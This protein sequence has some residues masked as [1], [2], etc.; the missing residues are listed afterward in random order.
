MLKIWLDNRGV[1][2]LLQPL[3]I[4]FYGPL[5]KAYDRECNLFLKSHPLRKI[6]NY[7]IAELFNKAYGRVAAIEKAVKGFATA[8]IYPL[9]PNIFDGDYPD[10]AD[11]LENEQQPCTCNDPLDTHTAVSL[12]DHSRQKP[13]HS[14][15]S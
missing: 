11:Q 14:L 1:I 3:D 6:T 2:I 7:D 8:G 9:D 4:C 15:R 12:G 5:K 10:F 13:L